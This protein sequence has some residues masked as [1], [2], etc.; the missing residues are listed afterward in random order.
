MHTGEPSHGPQALHLI[1]PKWCLEPGLRGW[2]L[3]YLAVGVRVRVR[4]RVTVRVRV[5]I[6]VRIRVRVRM[7]VRERVRG[8]NRIQ[9]TC[10]N[11]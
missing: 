3:E 8:N 10:N 9:L 4:V 2:G 5:R 1:V 7:S 11:N 6:R